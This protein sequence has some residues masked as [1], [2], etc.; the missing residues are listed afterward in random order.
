MTKNPT[1]ILSMSTKRGPAPE[2]SGVDSALPVGAAVLENLLSREDMLHILRLVTIG[3]LAASFA[4]EVNNALSLID[5]SVMLAR[6][7]L[8]SDHPVQANLAVISRCGKQI[9]DMSKRMLAFG[10]TRSAREQTYDIQEV[11]YEAVELMQPHFRCNNIAVRME[12]PSW[13]PKMRVERWQILQALV[14]L[15]RNACDAV[16]KTSRREVS[17]SVVHERQEIRMAVADTGSGIQPQSLPLIFD[18]F[19]TTKGD[20]GTGLGLY[21]TRKIIEDHHGTIEVQTGPEGTTFTIS[22]PLLQ[23]NGAT[24]S[25]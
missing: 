10:R 22:L 20:R 13:I 8:P 1:E 2:T 15:L 9:D 14:N 12:V 6:E 24:Y 17:I 25:P 19:F 7:A 16:A 5:G 3:Q 21:V 23:G 18:P 4:H 11:V